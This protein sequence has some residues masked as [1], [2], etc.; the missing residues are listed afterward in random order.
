VLARGDTLVLDGGG[1]LSNRGGWWTPE[2][3]VGWVERLRF[4]GMLGG[5]ATRLNVS[6]IDLLRL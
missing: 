6:G 4:E 1:R 3:D 5:R 2:K